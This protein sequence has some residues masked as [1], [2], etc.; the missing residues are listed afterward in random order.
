M[1][2]LDR[3]SFVLKTHTPILWMYTEML[4]D[5]AVPSDHNRSSRHTTTQRPLT[6]KWMGPWGGIYMWG[7]IR[8]IFEVGQTD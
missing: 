7:W 6:S 1:E 3:S 8:A 2:N 5:L 4:H